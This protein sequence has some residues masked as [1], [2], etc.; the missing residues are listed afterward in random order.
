MQKESSSSV[1]IFYPRYNR[2][3]LILKLKSRLGD[4]EKELPLLSVILFGSYAEGRF[5]VA[6][7]I[8]L[9]VIYKGRERKNAFSVVKKTLGIPLLEPH[10]YSE[11]EYERLKENIERMIADGVVLFSR[12]QSYNNRM[13]Q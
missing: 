7:D 5:T 2:E 13:S 10:I 1:R 8:D 12:D 11:V 6:S 3:E 4:L 9:L